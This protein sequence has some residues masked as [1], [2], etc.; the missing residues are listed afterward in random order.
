M[1]VFFSKE[2]F[3]LWFVEADPEQEESTPDHPQRVEE[4]AGQGG[5]LDLGEHADKGDV[6]EDPDGG[7][8]QP[9]RELPLGTEHQPSNLQLSESEGLQ[10]AEE[11][12]CEI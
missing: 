11:S 1:V 12:E 9:G 5:C 6:E 7:S 2:W 3:Q 8:Q 4:D 10:L